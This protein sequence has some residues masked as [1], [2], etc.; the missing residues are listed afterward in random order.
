MREENTIKW[1]LQ[2]QMDFSNIGFCPLQKIVFS[3]AEQ[4]FILN[5]VRQ[6]AKIG[7]PKGMKCNTKVDMLLGI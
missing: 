1:R 2:N 7:D 4:I 3:G 6:A 5:E